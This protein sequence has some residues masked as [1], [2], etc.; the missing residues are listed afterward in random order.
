MRSNRI[1]AY[2]ASVRM[3]QIACEN[4]YFCA[5]VAH[6]HVK[7][8]ACG[9]LCRLQAKIKNRKKNNIQIYETLTLAVAAATALSSPSLWPDPPSAPSPVPIA[10]AR[11]VR[12]RSAATGS[13]RGLAAAAV[14]RHLI[15]IAAV[16]VEE[17]GRG[18]RRPPDRPGAS[19]SARRPCSR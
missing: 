13:V 5:R 17:E 9:C 19:S 8:F 3:E 15:I 14:A 18:V 16:S 11:S 2:G 12:R 1:F 6:P 4:R 10:V 7:I